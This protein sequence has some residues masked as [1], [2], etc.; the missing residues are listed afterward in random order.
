MFLEKR[1]FIVGVG[2]FC[3]FKIGRGRGGA[4]CGTCQLTTFLV[5]GVVFN[6]KA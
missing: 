4:N 5:P 1:S 2:L 6:K 3:F